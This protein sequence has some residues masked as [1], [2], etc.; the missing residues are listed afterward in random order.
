MSGDR[1]S[2]L[3]AL[4]IAGVPGQYTTSLGCPPPWTCTVFDLSLA[5]G[6]YSMNQ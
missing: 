3:V 6:K 1:V 5:S 2:E 4:I